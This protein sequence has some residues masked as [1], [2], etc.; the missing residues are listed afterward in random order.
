[1]QAHIVE[2]DVAK[3]IAEQYPDSVLIFNPSYVLSK[4]HAL[5]A[6]ILAK[7]VM[8]S[9]QNIANKLAIEFLVRLSGQKKIQ[10]A[11]QYGPRDIG[12]VAGIVILDDAVSP[13]GIINIPFH[14]DIGMICR[15][16][17]VSPHT[18]KEE[19]YE[20]MAMVDV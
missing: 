19:I 2:A 10:K 20:K 13:D 4:D 3:R 14:P 12:G 18:A 11:L 15:K 7:K 16:Y 17:A 8:A 5:F 9:G 1:M 6:A